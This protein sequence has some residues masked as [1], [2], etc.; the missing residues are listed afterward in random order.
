MKCQNSTFNAQCLRIIIAIIHVGVVIRS[1]GGTQEKGKR[2][3][4]SISQN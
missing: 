3:R 1:S 2:G 4:N